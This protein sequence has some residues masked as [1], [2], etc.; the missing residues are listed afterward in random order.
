MAGA[1]S[2]G[3]PPTL[4][5]WLCPLAA[6]ALADVAET[7]REEGRPVEPVL[8]RLAVLVDR[9]PH[10]IADSTYVSAAYGAQLDALDTLYAAEVARARGTADASVRWARAAHLLD[11]VWPWDAAYATYRAGEAVLVRG[12]GSRD[13]AATLLRRAAQLATELRA[14]PVLREVVE[15][16]RSARIPLD[17]VQPAAPGPR[18]ARLPG[19]TAREREVLQHVVAGRT[20]GEIARALFV[21]EKTVSSHI[22]NL[23]RKTG[24]SNR[25][26]LARLARHATAS[27][28]R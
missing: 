4:C 13:E 8:E 7:A 21:S 15:L 25:V 3:V 28:P 18:D 27:P 9:F 23:L 11:G 10:V 24:A 12:G 22:S 14:E 19:L 2:P 16:A 20:Y 6:R 5:E 26:E 1:L 17:A